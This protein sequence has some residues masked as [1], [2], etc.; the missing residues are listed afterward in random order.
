MKSISLWAAFLTQYDCMQSFH[1][2]C[3]FLLFFTCVLFVLYFLAIYFKF[4]FCIWLFVSRQWD[5]HLV[6][7]IGCRQ[8]ECEREQID[9]NTKKMLFIKIEFQNISSLLAIIR[10]MAGWLGFLSLPLS[11]FSFLS[12][13]VCV[14]LLQVKCF[15][16]SFPT[17]RF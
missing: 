17:Q 15:D 14:S 13:S 8:E 4:L 10:S 1:S 11:L 16:C 2:A 5:A 7:P 6:I 12:F 3:F 9:H